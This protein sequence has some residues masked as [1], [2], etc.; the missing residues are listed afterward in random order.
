MRLLHPFMPFITEELYHAVYDGNPEQPCILS[1]FPQPAASETVAAERPL[2]LIS[3]VRQVRNSKGLSPKETLDVTLISQ[4]PEAYAGFEGIMA[5][6]A[7]CRLEINGVKPDPAAVALVD[8]DEM[9]V[10]LPA[11]LNLEEEKE[12][13]RKEIVYLEGFLK[14]VEVKLSNERFVA[15]AKPDVVEKEKQKKA[16]AEEKLKNLRAGLSQ[17]EG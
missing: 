15:N 9:Y 8:T 1:A 3:E 12:A 17:L 5:K 13:M 11:G 6:L 7:N 10:G 2:K 14:S 16:D 4:A